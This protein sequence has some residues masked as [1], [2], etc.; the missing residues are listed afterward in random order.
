MFDKQNEKLVCIFWVNFCVEQNEE[1]KTK[2]KQLEYNLTCHG[3]GLK[4]S[5]TEKKPTSRKFN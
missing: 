5:R 1:P 3:L 2:K 4:S